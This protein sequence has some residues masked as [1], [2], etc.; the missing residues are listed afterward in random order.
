MQLHSIKRKIKALLCRLHIL[1]D[2]SPK[3]FYIS[4]VSRKAPWVYVA[5]ITDVFYHRGNDALKNS[6][7]NHREALAQVDVFNEL[8]YNVYVQQYLSKRDIPNLKFD[9]VFGHEPNFVRAVE[10]NPDALKVHYVPGAYIDHRNGQIVRMTDYINKTYNSSIPYRRLL[11]YENPNHSSKFAYNLADKILMIG[12]KFTIETFPE[13]LHSKIV[14][15][16]QSTQLTHTIKDLDYAPSNEYFFMGSGGNLLKGIS[17]LVEYFSKHP[18][19]TINIVG[20]IEDDVKEALHH[21]LTDNIKC[22]G[23]V[24]V[25]SDKMVDIMKRCNF[26]IYPSGSE[27]MPGAVLNSMKNGLIPIVTRWAAFDEIEELGYVL[28]DWTVNAIDK[29]V[30]WSKSL[31]QNEVIDLKQKCSVYVENTYNIS[32]YRKEFKDFFVKAINDKQKKEAHDK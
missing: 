30:I 10:K 9:I 12:S 11:E 18:E 28:E 4:K 13:D 1:G 6:H 32:R 29:G 19:Y 27:G 7:Q 20:P 24:D 23:Y 15:I 14:T 3:D 5:Y 26:I 17:L 16:H 8:G 25:N 21:L 22:H 2:N 31:S